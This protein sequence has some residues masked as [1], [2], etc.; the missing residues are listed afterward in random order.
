MPGPE[1]GSKPTPRTSAFSLEGELRPE[2]FKDEEQALIAAKAW[3]ELLARYD[4]AAPRAADADTGRRLMWSAAMLSLELGNTA[5]AETHLRRVLATL[6]QQLEALEALV[7]IAADAKRHG[8]AAKLLLMAARVLSGPEAVEPLL[9]LAKLRREALHQPVLALE[10]LEHALA[11]DP[12]RVEVLDLAFEILVELR[13]YDEAKAVLDRETQADPRLLSDELQLTAAPD[14]PLRMR[15]KVVAGRYL[16]LGRQLQSEA[17]YHAISQDCLEKARQAG[18]QAALADLDRLAHTR[19]AWETVAAELHEAA[20]QNEDKAE[21]ASA[22]VEAAELLWLLGKD[23]AGADEQL[24]RAL[25]LVPGFPKALDVIEAMFMA[26]QRFS[27]LLVRFESHLPQVRDPALKAELLIRIAEFKESLIDPQSPSPEALLAIQKH[28]EGVFEGLS[29]HDLA[30]ARL[31]EVYRALG[32]AQGEA[33]FLT[34]QLEASDDPDRKV[35]LRRDLGRLAAERLGDSEA[36]C[37]HFAAI[38]SLR[39]EDFQAASALRALYKDA[40]RPAELFG[41]LC[42]MQRSAPSRKA[43]L[44]LLLEEEE[45]L[46]KLGDTEAMAVRLD[47]DRFEPDPERYQAELERLAEATE[48]YAPL[49]LAY[50][51]R[52]QRSEG[53]AELRA[54]KRAGAIYDEILKAP[55]QAIDAY[56][57]ALAKAPEDLPLRR[58]LERLLIEVDD[59]EALVAVRLSE[60]QQTEDPEARLALLLGIGEIQTQKLKAREAA[61]QSYE[62]ALKLSPGHPEALLALDGLYAALDQKPERIRILAEREAIETDPAVKVPLMRQRAELLEDE[63][64]PEAAAEL[65]LRVL[66]LAFDDAEC[67]GRLGRLHD[68]D[69]AGL[70]IAKALLPVYQREPQPERELRMWARILAD[71]E[72]EAERLHAAQAAARLAEDPLHDAKAAFAYMASALG[73][74]P[75]DA[76]LQAELF[77]LAEAGQEEA[78]AAQH[79]GRLSEDASTPAKAR[80]A[81]A[82]YEAKLQVSALDDSEAAILAYRRALDLDATSTEAITALEGL[83]GAKAAYDELAEL[84][85]RQIAL[86]EAPEG[87]ISLGLALADMR[88]SHLDDDD[89]AIEAYRAVLDLDPNH[90]AAVKGLTAALR[91]RARWPELIEALDGIRER[92]ADSAIQAG[93]ETQ[94]GDVLRVELTDFEAALAR[95]LN[96]IALEP[97]WPEAASGLE[98]LCEVPALRAR[99][100]AALEPGYVAEARWDAAIGV[101]RI[102]LSDAVDSKAKREL[103]LRLAQILETHQG[104]FEAAY[105]ALSDAAAQAWLLPEDRLWLITLAGKADRSKALASLLKGLL[106]AAPG[107]PDLTRDLA[108][109]YD[110][111][112]QDADAARA[113][114]ERLIDLAP[115]DNEA[116]EALERLT[117]QGGDPRALAE[118]LLQRAEASKELAN[119]LGFYRRAASVFEAQAGD[120]KQ[121][122]SVLEKAQ[123][124][125]PDDPQVLSELA[126]VYGLSTRHDDA[127]RV[128][129]ALTELELAPE[130]EA[131]AW[132][133]LAECELA[134]K[135]PEAAIAALERATEAKIDFEPAERL[136]E[137]QLETPMASEAALVLEPVYQ[138]KGEYAALA[139][140]YQLLAD[141]PRRE[142]ERVSRLVAIAG[143]YETQT[144]EPIKAYQT[145]VKAY[146]TDPSDEALYTLMERLSAPAEQDEAFHEVIEARLA[147]LSEGSEAR[148]ALF[149]TMAERGERLER[150]S[151]ARAYYQRWVDEA[152]D[153]AET[154]EHLLRLYEAAGETRAAVRLLCLMADR[155]KTEAELLR[156]LETAAGLLESPLSDLQAA[157]AIHQRILEISPED[158]KALAS[159]NRL[160]TET[161]QLDPLLEVL[162]LEAEI[163]DTEARG[164]TLVRLAS[165]LETEKDDPEGALLY[166]AEALKLDDQALPSKVEALTQLDRMRCTKE[167][168]E[169]AVQAARVVAPVWGE[170]GEPQ[171]QIDALWVCASAETG[172]AEIALQLEVAQIA[173]EALKDGPQALAALIEV[174]QAKREDRPLAERMIALSEA[175]AIEDTM[176][177][178]IQAVLPEVKDDALG[179][180]LASWAGSIFR[181]LGDAARAI[182]LFDLA[183]LRDPTDM[184]VLDALLKLHHEA[185]DLASELRVLRLQID[186]S[187]DPEA[188]RA[189]WAQIASLAEKSGDQSVR[190]EA[191]RARIQLDPKDQ[192]S[193]AVLVELC[194]E[195]ER[196]DELAEALL[197]QAE[198]ADAPAEKAA[199]FHRLAELCRHERQRPKEAVAYFQRVLEVAPGDKKAMQTLSTMIHAA[200]APGEAAAVLAPIFKERGQMEP[201]VR[202]LSSQAEYA[203]SVEAKL[204]WLMEISEVYEARLGR[205]EEALQYAEAAMTALP[206]DPA[207]RERL[208]VLSRRYSAQAEL[209]RFYDQ[210]SEAELSPELRLTLR[211]R[212]AEIAD[213]DLGDTERAID[214]YSR[215]LD[216]SGDD[217]EALKALERL[218]QAS[219]RFDSLAEVYQR[220][221]AQAEDSEVRAGLMRQYARLQSGELADPDGAILTLKRLLG[222]APDDAAALQSLVKLCAAEGR[223][224]ELERELEAAVDATQVQSESGQLARVSLA[225]LRIA[226]GQMDLAERLLDEVLA[227]APKHLQARAILENQF[228]EAISDENAELAE[229]LGRVL[230]K[231]L[232]AVGDFAGLLAILRMRVRVSARPLERVPLNREIAKIYETEL[233]QAE[234]AFAA[235]AEVVKDAPGLAAD[236]DELERLGAALGFHSELAEVYGQAL[237]RA[238]DSELQ[239]ALLRRMAQIRDSWGDE[240]ILAIS[241]WRELLKRQPLDP[242]A[243]LALDRL[244][245][246]GGQASA[247]ADILEQRLK[248]ANFEEEAALRL[249]LAR[250]WDEELGE[251]TEAIRSYRRLVELEPTG[252]TALLALARLLD[253][254]SDAEEL[255][256]V[257]HVLSETVE[258]PK[259]RLRF[260]QRYAA[261]LAQTGRWEQAVARYK[262][263]LSLE[264]RDPDAYRALEAIYAHQEA[265]EALAEL[266]EEELSGHP[267]SP[268]ELRLLRAQGDLYE[269]RLDDP[270]RAIQAYLRVLK[271]DPGDCESLEALCRVYRRAERWPELGEALKKLIPLSMD[272]IEVK[273]LRFDLAEL[274]QDKLQDMKLATEHARRALDIEPHSPA[275][276]VR[277]EALFQATGAHAE[278]V[279][280]LSSMAEKAQAP[281]EEIEL[282]MR[283]ADIALNQLKRRALAASAY[284]RALTLDSTRSDAFMGVCRIH[285]ENGDYRKL[286]EVLNRRLAKVE[287]PAERRDLLLEMARMYEVRLG[288]PDLA[289]LT[290][291]RAFGEPGADLKALE[292]AARLADD[293]TDWESLAEAIE[294][295]IDDVVPME[296]VPLRRQLAEI[297]LKRLED[298]D[299]QKA[300][301]QLEMALSVRPEDA[302]SRE[303]LAEILTRAG[304]YDELIAGLREQI[305]VSRDPEQRLSLYR[306]LAVEQERNLKDP[307]AA[308]LSYRHILEVKPSDMEAL[309]ELSRLYRSMKSWQPLLGVLRRKLELAESQEDRVAAR[310]QIAVVW[311]EGLN[312][313]DQAIEAYGDVLI[314]DP[315]N[316]AALDAR[317]RLYTQ[318]ERWIDLIDNTERL[319]E[320]SP[321]PE[322]QVKR[323]TQISEIWQLRFRD[324]EAAANTM[325]RALEV[326]FKHLPSLDRLIQLLGE[327][328]EHEALIAALRRKLALVQEPSARVKLIV[329]IGDVQRSALQDLSA[330]EISY[331]EAI[332]INPQSAEAVHALGEL[333]EAR[334]DAGEALRRIQ[335]ELSLVGLTSKAVMLYYRQGLLE[336]TALNDHHAAEISFRRA[337]EQDPGHQPSLHALR[338]IFDEAGEFGEVAKL[339]AQEAE[340]TGDEEER[341]VLYA[342]AA[343]IRLEHF[344]DVRGAIR[345]YELALDA[346]PTDAEALR[347]ISELYIAEE[348]WETAEPKLK[349]LIN[350]LDKHE[351]KEELSRSSYRLAYLYEKLGNDAEALRRYHESYEYDPSYLPTLEALGAALARVERWEDA[352]NILRTIL[353]QHRDLLTDAEVVDLYHQL[354]QLCERLSKEGRARDNYDRALDL[355]PRHPATLRAASDLAESMKEWE[356]AYDLRERLIAGLS[357]EPRYEAALRQARLCEEEIKEP[358]RAIDAYTEARRFKPDERAHVKALVRL[359]KETGQVA[360]AIDMQAELAAMTENPA[361]QRAAWMNLATL[362]AGHGDMDKVVSSLNK[363]LDVDPSHLQAF[364]HIE[365]ILS[366]AK[367][368]KSLEQNYHAMI[369]RVPRSDKTRRMVLWKSLGELYE[370]GLHDE[371][372]ARQAYEVILRKLNP[373]DDEVAMRLAD[374]YCRNHDTV[375]KALAL[376]HQFVAT[377]DDP[378]RVARHL[379]EVYSALGQTDRAYA[380]LGALVLMQAANPGEKEAYRKLQKRLPKA[381]PKPISDQMWRSLLFHPDCRSELGD[382]LS[383]LYRGAPDLF[384]SKQRMLQLKKK[385]RV[386]MAARGRSA[387]VRLRYFAV[388]DKLQKAMNVGQMAHYNR[389]GV[390]DDPRLCPG[391]EPVLYAGEGSA[392]FRPTTDERSLKWRLARQ[393]TMARPELAAVQ[394]LAPADVGAILEAAISLVYPDGSGVDLGLDG[395]QIDAWERNLERYLSPEAKKALSDVVP[396]VMKKRE[397][398]HLSRFLEGAEHTASRAALLM[399]GDTETAEKG[400]LESD[401]VVSV[402]ARSRVRELMLFELSEEHF[403]LREKL[404]LA[405]QA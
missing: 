126:R 293:E 276:L 17:L 368:W 99:A 289:F 194:A 1:V 317:E 246:E 2:I 10:A 353:I 373:T 143:L 227:E 231:P 396:P 162:A 251:R 88:E 168:P 351:D 258:E 263:Q 120:L 346:V 103:S 119:Q 182:A 248:R 189:G 376:Y 121:A 385:E 49:A 193:L 67:I 129:V 158:P 215:V 377:V 60:L 152:P 238:P 402:S 374:L 230:A 312:Q 302:P 30:E 237:E 73:L 127:H 254:E 308:A 113:Y 266:Y 352:Q 138:A 27:E 313:P 24:N 26:D 327:A 93:V 185:G 259:E 6:P 269:R 163:L 364:Q 34:R 226:A 243:L 62:A 349:A 44:E 285:E 404:G 161:E 105:E 399:T 359:Y 203:E 131:Q 220:R 216:L 192:Q 79:F 116:L 239:V 247:L 150:A 300:E 61:A 314:L 82:L 281:S 233:D 188:Q 262:L 170:A 7:G 212:I 183:H 268:E 310:S 23:A 334:G 86:S 291:L 324:L 208:E 304:R 389:P 340:H 280:V 333:A 267:D 252:K 102:Q 172:E 332:R 174:H 325:E 211:R 372:G 305:E 13:R 148:L 9:F 33:R 218:Y 401:Q 159:L 284:D 400:L 184:G 81:L 375:P 118:V 186:L 264:P 115:G 339:L 350:L 242:E 59:P 4:G 29:R 380:T 330:A 63:A 140:A 338:E 405:I 307:E 255:L 123:G 38:H 200:E 370:R 277:L 363:A 245:S 361:S 175:F 371:A 326:D 70:A 362:Y 153:D 294:D 290:A 37:G 69:V 369:R 343:E 250:L 329:Q 190:L 240:P 71:G 36:A 180:R 386:D 178:H 19:T 328:G 354:G 165:L 217:I 169:L 257:L 98:A 179:H 95:Y 388:W 18:E 90:E 335:E 357:G 279:R 187:E 87:Q 55:R 92:S 136:L 299:P 78:E 147:E 128:L 160:Y 236:R 157:I 383:V 393:L 108:R 133:S 337:L 224:Q 85:S 387:R 235:Y 282:Q 345:D 365:K 234:M 173:E 137:A 228:E 43:S 342:E 114:W 348:E 14:D 320:L 384:A 287:D 122:L 336:E 22:Y 309:E 303:L 72:T 117:A 205:P 149:R 214:E 132:V 112:A 53:E 356:R 94:A 40:N 283:I 35:D 142:D 286:V 272:A 109:L 397:M 177:E 355:D 154:A 125:A 111:P 306:Q 5:E 311:D 3:P 331:A 341:A 270:D 124:I 381:D 367:A 21:A 360:R 145:A 68:E 322:A 229:R 292:V 47:L 25:L 110:G 297:Y 100:A 97:A 379:T 51:D 130:A 398:K 135:A 295:Q 256:S 225:E 274:Y 84:L 164:Q 31:I 395:A 50:M 209:L 382:L 273:R 76:E 199:I 265:Y 232:R 296:A 48:A 201:Y 39:P 196:F 366:E 319:V 210:L 57:T 323:L 11:F 107:D 16:A 315:E 28:Y 344:D 206:E 275:E 195:L 166:Y 104:A 101:L 45:L 65:L 204:A 96:A 321:D 261:L 80:S 244:Y 64:Q 198:L 403:L 171:R 191:Y 91:R 181:D 223:S 288:H 20:R 141:D 106:E 271:K 74:N 391:P 202:A 176:A 32:D 89:G 144:Q 66:Q 241:A 156:R 75:S 390:G 54:L 83:Y 42:L 146:Q 134:L 207:S 222:F 41:V 213:H 219:G 15:Q 155:A 52:A 394:A 56:K 260:N 139:E 167:R 347:A 301:H 12:N 197:R 316:L 278:A 358:Y 318:E 221:I 249:R 58:A 8:E 77:R 378:A 392:I 151:E 253:P 298:P 46:S